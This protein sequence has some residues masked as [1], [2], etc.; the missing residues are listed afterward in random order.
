MLTFVLHTDG[1]YA[2]IMGTVYDARLIANVFIRALVRAARLL[3]LQKL[4]Y[5]AQGRLSIHAE[6]LIHQDLEAWPLSSRSR[7]I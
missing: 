3:H 2:N 4:V 5:F 1:I 6:R 7:F